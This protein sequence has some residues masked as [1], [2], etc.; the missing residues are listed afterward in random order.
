MGEQPDSVHQTGCPS[1][2][3]AQLALKDPKIDFDLYGRYGGVGSKPDYNSG[4]IMVM[5]H[6]VTNEYQLSR[7]HIEQTLGAIAKVGLPVFWFWP[8]P[9][10]GA[11]GTST[12][13]RS[14]RENHPLHHVHFFKSMEPL[15]F[16]KLLIH[17]KCLVGN[18]STGLRE[19]S[20]LGVPAV[21]IGSRQKGRDRAGNVLDVDY[22]EGAILTAIN[23]R[24]Q[25]KKPE[26]SE[27]Y[28]SGNAGKK[29]ADILAE[30]PLSHHKTIAY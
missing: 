25:M 7:K 28:G 8:N 15:H 10:A 22:D 11:D 6:P 12:G 5:Q 23:E 20:F 1:I 2:D 27:L 4:F 26:T 13:I 17:C 16:L 9:D 18:S 14:Y 24:L 19:G 21:N 30:A 29:I 3:L